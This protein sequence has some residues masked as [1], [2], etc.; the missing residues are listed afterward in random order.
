MGNQNSYTILKNDQDFSS[1][2]LEEIAELKIEGKV[3]TPLSDD[4]FYSLMTEAD[5]TLTS[6]SKP[7]PKKEN[8]FDILVVDDNEM[9]RMLA[10]RM[11]V[12]VFPNTKVTLAK[13]GQEAIKQTTKNHFD[14]V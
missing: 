8:A 10:N 7:A 14:L 12:G 6:Q 1:E 4:I 11:L 9:N 13:S 5:K 3:C 2:Q